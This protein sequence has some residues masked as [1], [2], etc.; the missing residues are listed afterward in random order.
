MKTI[1][2]NLRESDKT[3]LKQRG[4]LHPTSKN[5]LFDVLADRATEYYINIPKSK[6][7]KLVINEIPFWKYFNMECPKSGFNN[8][9]KR[10]NSVVVRLSYD[11]KK[12]PK[13]TETYL[14][15]YLLK[16]LEN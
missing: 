6:Y 13:L 16:Q 3:L 7:H 5:N 11:N 8:F 9:A 10:I 14:R 2:L 15:N 12:F 1:T 4:L